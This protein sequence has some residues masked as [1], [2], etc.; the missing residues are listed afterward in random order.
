VSNDLTVPKYFMVISLVYRS[1]EWPPPLG[2]VKEGRR[3]DL[4]P[5]TV[6]CDW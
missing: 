4:A 2:D 5:R 3:S 1:R 6:D